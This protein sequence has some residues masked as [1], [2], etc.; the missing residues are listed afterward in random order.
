MN[1]SSLQ[2]NLSGHNPLLLNLSR[3]VTLSKEMR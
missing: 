3:L 2:L 1:G